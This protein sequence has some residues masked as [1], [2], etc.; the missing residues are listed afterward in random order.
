LVR[1]FE[2]YLNDIA[3][4]PMLSREEEAELARRSRAGDDTARH[5]LVSANL[6]FVVSIAK[7]YRHSAV[8][9]A[10]LVNEGNLGLLRA[11]ERFDETHG[12]R[13]VS[14][15]IWWI[16]QG[17]VRA[18]ARDAELNGRN[19]ASR[20]V[21]LD[22]PLTAASTAP[23]QEVVP[24]ERCE[25]PEERV[26][27]RALRDAVDSSLTDLPEREQLVLRLYYGLDG[28][29]PYT[30]EEVGQRLGVTRERVRQI[31]ERALARLRAGA[32]R[33]GLAAYRGNAPF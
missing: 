30:L 7:R 18:I 21:S 9:L 4:H 5:R 33:H 1:L 23:L 2:R 14:Y 13:F 17:M 27:Q 19:G 28:A 15:A 10:D 29:P 6:R 11:A 12:V 31:K 24:D 22:Q 3:R 16:R 20:R 8:P 25:A 32:R 26:M